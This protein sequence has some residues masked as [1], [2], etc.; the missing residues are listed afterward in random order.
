MRNTGQLKGMPY[1][2]CQAVQDDGLNV[3]VVGATLLLLILSVSYDI[4]DILCFVNFSY[5]VYWQ[6]L[7]DNY[8]KIMRFK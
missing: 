8:M 4:Y 3:L 1:L 7:S 5:Y 2:L 6:N